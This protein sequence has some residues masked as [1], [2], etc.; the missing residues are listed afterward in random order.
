[1]LGA[2]GATETG[3]VMAGAAGLALDAPGP[4]LPV[5]MYER[6]PEEDADEVAGAGAEVAN[7]IGALKDATGAAGAADFIVGEE[8]ELVLHLRTI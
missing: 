5:G 4:Q 6:P 1:M 7:D 2:E 8:R 3:A